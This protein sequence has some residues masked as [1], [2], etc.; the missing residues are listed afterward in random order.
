[1]LKISDLTFS[2]RPVESALTVA[3]ALGIYRDRQGAV[4]DHVEIGSTH[5]PG[6][7]EESSPR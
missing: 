1:M 7:Q 6:D 2:H 4:T 5:I 3:E